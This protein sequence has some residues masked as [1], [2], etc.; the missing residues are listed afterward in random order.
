MQTSGRLT[1]AGVLGRIAAR[2]G[3]RPAPPGDDPLG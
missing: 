3:R 2:F 1:L